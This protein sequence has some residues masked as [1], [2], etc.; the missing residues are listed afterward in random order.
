MDKS[1]ITAILLA[2]GQSSRMNGEDKALVSYRGQPLIQHVV[3][4]VAPQVGR[5]LVSYNRIPN[6]LDVIDF[7]LDFRVVSD[8]IEGF[9]GPLA[10]IAACVPFINSALTL[11]V[12]CDTPK[13]PRDLVMQMNQAMGG[14]EQL[15]Y[16]S[17]PLRSHPL[18]L[19]ARTQVLETTK[20][21]LASGRRSVMG[22][23]ESQ[24]YGVVEFADGSAFE[25][26]NSLDQLEQAGKK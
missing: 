2:G 11:V 4:C 16:A 21:Y 1:D 5:F 15:V 8:D 13:L 6:A 9:Q 7:K 19:L 18:I 20:D 10:G 26:L 14:N 25:N 22:W 23:C 12:P 3:N 17:D 24:V